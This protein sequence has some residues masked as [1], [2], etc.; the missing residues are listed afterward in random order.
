MNILQVFADV[1]S[2]GLDHVL[3]LRHTNSLELDASLRLDLLDE[4]FR[5]ARVESD[6][7]TAGTCT[8]S[9]STSVD[10]GLSLLGWLNLDDQVHIGNVKSTGS[11]IS[12]DQDT[13][14]SFLEALHG[15]FTLILRNV[16]MHHFNV[17]LDLI[18]QKKRVGIGLCLREDNDLSSLSVHYENIGECRQTVL[19]GA[20]DSQMLHITGR[21][22]LEIDS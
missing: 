14:F 21:L 17:L 9:S 19:E 2:T 22:V 15:Y 6:A 12:G 5:L 18:R 11:D 3:G 20:L 1:H 4:H 7:S 16:T 10:V 13:E 8:S